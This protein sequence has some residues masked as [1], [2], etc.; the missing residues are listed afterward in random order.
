MAESLLVGRNFVFGI[1]K[2]KPKK[3]KKTKK[4]KTY[5]SYKNVGFYQPRYKCDSTA[6]RLP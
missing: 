6:A 1:C 2:L 5:I 3:L 4:P